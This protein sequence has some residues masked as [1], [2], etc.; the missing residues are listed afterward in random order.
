MIPKPKYKKVS[1]D[2]KWKK[3][4][5]A[6]LKTVEIENGW[7]RCSTE[8]NHGCGRWVQYPEVDHIIKR[9]VRPDLKYDPT[10]LQ[11]LCHEC[12]VQKDGGMAA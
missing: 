2:W 9:S 3:T 6:Y 10:N 12:H 11:V 8:N 5:E 4:R 1:P 7:Y